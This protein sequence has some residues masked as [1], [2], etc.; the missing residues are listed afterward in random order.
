MYV[1]FQDGSKQHR[2]G[3]GDIVD[4]DYRPLEPGDTIEFEKVL[5]CSRE[6]GVIVGNPTIPNAKVRARVVGKV[7]GP[8]LHIVRFRRRKNS[9][10]RVGHREP[11]TRVGVEEITVP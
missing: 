5:M 10:R 6:D 2:V 3:E 7:K 9:R 8:K 1:V 11:Y 4:V